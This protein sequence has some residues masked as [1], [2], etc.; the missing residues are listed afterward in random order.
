[1]MSFGHALARVALADGRADQTERVVMAERLQR[2]K[3]FSGTE[4]DLIVNL[5]LAQA[6][7]WDETNADN[8]TRQDL[9]EALEAVA[10]ADEVVTDSERDII[11]ELLEG[12]NS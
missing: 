1:M 8:A 10:A 5:A 3:I 11:R 4:I 2:G 9:A 12:P 7:A 6:R